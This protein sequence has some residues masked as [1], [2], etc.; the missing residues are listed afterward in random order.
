MTK[1]LEM[2][3]SGGDRE[4][5][6]ECVEQVLWGINEVIEMLESSGAR[7]MSCRGDEP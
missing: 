6:A 7:P 1:L 5:I 3:R 2:I 4:R